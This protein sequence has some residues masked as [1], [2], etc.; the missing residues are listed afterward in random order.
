MQFIK[1]KKFTVL[2]FLFIILSFNYIK[3]YYSNINKNI[4]K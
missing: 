4:N 1:N 2:I 3:F